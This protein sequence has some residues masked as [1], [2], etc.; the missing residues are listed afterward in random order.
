MPSR[1]LAVI[2]DYFSFASTLQFQRTK[3]LLFPYSRGHLPAFP[4]LTRQFLTNV[5]APSQNISLLKG[6]LFPLHV[7]CTNML[8]LGASFYAISKEFLDSN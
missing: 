3:I 8:S 1:E 2:I 7:C 5:F 4:S 6:A